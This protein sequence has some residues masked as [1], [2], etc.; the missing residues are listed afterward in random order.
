MHSRFSLDYFLPMIVDLSSKIQFQIANP[1]RRL[2]GLVCPSPGHG[3]HPVHLPGTG[4]WFEN[5]AKPSIRETTAAYH[6]NCIDK[7][8]APNIGKIK[9]NKQRYVFPI[10]FVEN[11]LQCTAG[12]IN[13][14]NDNAEP[15]ILIRLRAESAC[16]SALFFKP[17]I[18]YS[19]FL[20]IITNAS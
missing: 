11:C 8:I 17:G 3:G 14:V 5:F 9:P 18:L 15:L 13:S 19:W 16:I 20:V 12:Y 2:C 1:C 7:H 10:L 4:A 6:K